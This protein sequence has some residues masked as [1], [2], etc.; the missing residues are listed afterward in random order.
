MAAHPLTPFL[1]HTLREND[2]D[3]S[4]QELFARLCKNCASDYQYYGVEYLET[5]AYLLR[6]GNVNINLHSQDEDKNTPLI[7]VSIAGCIDIIDILLD[8]GADINL[9]DNEGNTALMLAAMTVK[10]DAVKLLCERGA[11]LTLVNNDGKSALELAEKE[12]EYY[13][14]DNIDEVNI[15]MVDELKKIIDYLRSYTRVGGKRVTR[16]QRLFNSPKGGPKTRGIKYATAANARKS[17]KLIR[18]QDKTKR[19]SIAMRMY[20][21]AKYHKYQTPGMRGAMKVWK[22]YID[23]L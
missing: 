21:R 17:I 18:G 11:N 23:S 13:N 2:P 6:Y 14:E 15:N 22:K 20:Y 9:T 4:N 19:K 12:N 3:I 8:N 10:Y 7:D 1:L 5:I 16:K